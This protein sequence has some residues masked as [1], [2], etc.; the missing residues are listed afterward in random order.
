M[1][2]TESDW[3]PLHEVI[4]HV[5]ATQKCHGELAAKLI[6]AAVEGQKAKS[7]TVANPRPWTR[8]N[9][10]GS[11]IF[12]SAP[13]KS[14]EVRREDVLRLWPENPAEVPQACPASRKRPR[15]ISDG[16]LLA[17]KDL[18]SDE[19]PAGL[20]TQD[21]EKKIAMWLKEHGRSVSHALPK[22]VQ[23]ARSELRNRKRD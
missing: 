10:A 18:W 9:V 12:Y 13:E 6:Y 23:R 2:K 11:V 19:I 21:V 22:A 14:I 3:M 20:R 7:R 5:E 1:R 8:E 15:P 4:A 16:I 17:I